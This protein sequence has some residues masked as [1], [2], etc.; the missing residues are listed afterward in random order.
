MRSENTALAQRLDADASMGERAAA[1]Q[2][3]MSRV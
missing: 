3:L 1:V 2:S